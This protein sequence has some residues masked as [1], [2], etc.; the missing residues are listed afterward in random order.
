[1]NFYPK[2]INSL[3]ELK[4]E[5]QKLLTES[6]KT[7][8]KQI[9]SLRDIISKKES[10]KEEQKNNDETMLRGLLKSDSIE[11]VIISLTMPVLQK[12]GIKI[13]SIGK[14]IGKKVVVSTAKE[15][16]G[17]YLK[18]KAAELA[19]KGLALFLKS[20]RKHRHQKS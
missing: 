16:L 7:D 9:L 3:E 14:D 18:W 20:R 13:G 5:K 2:K 8:I 10:P 1:M 19:Y 4:L 6:K 17:G 11:E 15:I 12:A